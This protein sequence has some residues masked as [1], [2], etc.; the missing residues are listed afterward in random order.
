[1]PQP[2]R[3]AERRT[4]QQKVKGLRDQPG[5]MADEGDALDHGKPEIRHPL[6]QLVDTFSHQT[7][8]AAVTQKFN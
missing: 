3:L 5:R 7:G 4:S 8:I 2:Y 1:M 6:R